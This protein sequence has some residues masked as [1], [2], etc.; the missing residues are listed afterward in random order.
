MKEIIC[1]AILMLINIA[2]IFGIA[3]FL[4]DELAFV[5]LIDLIK[6]LFS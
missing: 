3:A 2:V 5:S 4:L 6:G 1:D